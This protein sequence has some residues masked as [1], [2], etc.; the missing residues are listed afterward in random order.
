MVGGTDLYDLL[1]LCAKC[2]R[3]CGSLPIFGLR[4]TFAQALQKSRELG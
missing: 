2:L 4:P 1:E 3:T